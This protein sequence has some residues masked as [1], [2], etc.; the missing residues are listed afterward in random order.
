[1]FNINFYLIV[2]VFP[3]VPLTFSELCLRF[4]NWY[5]PFINWHICPLQNIFFRIL[6][7]KYLIPNNSRYLSRTIVIS[8]FLVMH[9]WH[10]K[11]VYDTLVIVTHHQTIYYHD[12]VV[13]CDIFFKLT[14]FTVHVFSIFNVIILSSLGMYFPA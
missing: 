14:F 13:S 12:D 7:L 10:Q 11:Y 2:T 3:H 5:L 1:M 8:V 6:L 9:Y 4:Y